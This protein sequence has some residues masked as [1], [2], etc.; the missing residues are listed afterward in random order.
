[1]FAQIHKNLRADKIAIFVS[2]STFHRWLNGSQPQLWHLSALDA[3]LK[4]DTSLAYVRNFTST[5]K[6]LS[7]IQELSKVGEILACSTLNNDD[8][9]LLGDYHKN[10][11]SKKINDKGFLDD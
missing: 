2:K 1:M 9:I 11:L 6:Q 10:K 5:A 3:V 8:K 4:T 7:Q